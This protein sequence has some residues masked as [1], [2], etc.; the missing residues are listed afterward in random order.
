[1]SCTTRVLGIPF[2]RHQ[3]HKEVTHAE[4]LTAQEPDMWA[5]T[6]FRDYVRCDK[7]QV[8]TVCGEV[9]GAVS[10]LCEPEQADR[11][12]IRIEYFAKKATAPR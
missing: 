12:A 7:R 9:R 11:C 5:R 8:C 3:W 2:G 10:C 6:V 4:I 1:M